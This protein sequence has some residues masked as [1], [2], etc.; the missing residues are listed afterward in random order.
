MSNHGCV[1]SKKYDL[2]DKILKVLSR[3]DKGR[4]TKFLSNELGESVYKISQ[5][6]L[7]DPRI[8]K[9]DPFSGSWRPVDGSGGDGSA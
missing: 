7:L 9:D 4:S 8:E 1:P 3:Y 2:G 6:C 5:I